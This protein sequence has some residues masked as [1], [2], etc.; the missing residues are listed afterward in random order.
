[1]KDSLMIGSCASGSEILKKMFG[2]FEPSKSSLPDDGCGGLSQGL[3]QSIIGEE[4]MGFEDATGSSTTSTGPSDWSESTE[5]LGSDVS[6]KTPLAVSFRRYSPG[7]FAFV[8]ISEEDELTDESTRHDHSDHGQSSTSEEEMIKSSTVT[9]EHTEEN[10]WDDLNDNHR[11]MEILVQG[12]DHVVS[13]NFNLSPSPYFKLVNHYGNLCDSFATSSLMHYRRLVRRFEIDNCDGGSEDQSDTDSSY[14]SINDYMFPDELCYKIFTYL[15]YRFV[16]LKC[17]L[18]NRQFFSVSNSGTFW[19]PFTKSRKFFKSIDILSHY[20]LNTTPQPI[21]SVEEPVTT[22]T[23]L[24]VEEAFG[25]EMKNDTKSRQALPEDHLT[26]YR[27]ILLSFLHHRGSLTQWY[28]LT[29]ANYYF[30]F[31]IPIFLITFLFL[32]SYVFPIFPPFFKLN[33][34]TQ[35]STA[36]SIALSPIENRLK[37]TIYIEIFGPTFPQHTLATFWLAILTMIASFSLIWPI[38]SIVL[39]RYNLLQPDVDSCDKSSLVQSIIHKAKRGDY[40]DLFLSPTDVLPLSLRKQLFRSILGHERSWKKEQYVRSLTIVPLVLCY[41]STMLKNF[42]YIPVISDTCHTLLGLPAY[43]L[44]LFI[45]RRYWHVS[46]KT[47]GFASLLVFYSCF[48]FLMNQLKWDM[49][50]RPMVYFLGQVI[51]LWTY[52]ILNFVVLSEIESTTDP[53]AL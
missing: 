44:I 15:D 3:V 50:I 49:L 33:L 11:Q 35:L 18:V 2:P 52:I 24:T 37:R 26:I 32:S 6:G 1:M 42:V 53:C 51:G 41:V 13:H 10:V 4:A 16:V 12:V 36:T 34:F 28:Y 21:A 30:L 19:L 22:E 23:D 14:S 17:S 5:V 8:D 43:L 9:E 46:F 25:D 7:T 29:E 27:S 31:L 20:N 47:Q 39:N 40:R 38:T 45:V 48:H